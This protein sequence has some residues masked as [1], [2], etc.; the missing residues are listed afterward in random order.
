LL[1]QLVAAQFDLESTLAELSRN[2]ASTDAVRSSLEALG[3]LQR[4]VGTTNPARLELLRSEIAAGATNA[5]AIAQQT[6][7]SSQTESAEHALASVDART[8]ATVQRLAFDLFERRA[9]DP[10]LQFASAEEE[11]E[12]RRREAERKAYIERELARGTPEG[13]L[14]AATATVA[15]IDDAGA[16]GA[17]RSPDYD[18]MRADAISALDQQLAAMRRV[19]VESPAVEAVDPERAESPKSDLD[20]I[21]AIFNAAGVLPPP[22]EAEPASGHGLNTALNER[23]G[24][25]AVRYT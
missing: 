7:A 17:D 11:A 21:A 16:N 2:G 14:N 8:R 1:G 19:G 9:L 24:A 22:H 6:R 15:Q 13:N 4:Q 20:E 12:Y 3:D 18:K 25:A 5:R 23:S 10:Y